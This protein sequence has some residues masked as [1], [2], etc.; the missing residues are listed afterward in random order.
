MTATATADLDQEHDDRIVVISDFRLKDN[1]KAVPGARWDVHRRIWTIPRTWPA[2]LALRAEL[3]TYLSLGDDLRTWARAE[4]ARKTRLRELHVTLDGGFEVPTWPGFEGMFPH[5]MTGAHAIALAQRYLITDETG[6]GKTRT[7]LAG[8]AMLSY[9]REIIF[10]MLIVAPKSMLKT[11]A[12]EAERF[13]PGSGIRLCRGTPTNIKREM[14]P[15]GDIYIVGYNSLRSYS[16]LA[17]YGSTK[18]TDDQKVDK[19]LQE[20]HFQSLIADEAHRV[21]TPTAQQTRALWAAAKG[22]PFRVVMTGTP[23]Q[24]TPE[25]LW[26]LLHLTDSL[27]Y[28]SKTGYVERFLQVSW[29]QWGGRDI[30]GLNPLHSDEFFSN[31][32]AMSRRVTKEM[33][34]PFLP[35]KVHETRWVQLPPKLRKS[36]NSMRDVL[37]AE[38]ET[39]TMSA[40]NV[41]EKAGRLVQ[42][43]NASGDVDEDGVYTMLAPSP[44]IDAFMEDIANGDYDGRQVIVFSDSRQLIDLLSE[45]MNAKKIAHLS[46]T[47]DVTGEDRDAAMESFQR[48]DVQYILLTRAGGEGITLT[49]ANTMVRLVRAWSLTVHQQAE[50]RNHRIGSE[51]HDVITYVDYITED[52]VEEGQLVRLNAKKGRAEEVLRDKELLALLTEKE[53]TDDGE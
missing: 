21:K 28:P 27:E 39:T 13:F 4:A 18:L 38:L 23:I 26:A 10:P 6:T 35:P 37:V 48:G 33:A 15:G 34:L 2:C 42:L 32:D 24:D 12:G 47:G 46:I 40:K 7:S 17:P 41:L 51:I 22:A 25:D 43:A 1:V 44:K 19:Q 50:D 16:R 49:A 9:E 20:I 52:T 14:E 5:Q 36:Y 3:G 31:F 8:L 45:E 29:N 30:D 53:D 11:W